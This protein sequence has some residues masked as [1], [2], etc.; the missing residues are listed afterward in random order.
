[1]T[2]EQQVQNLELEL[3]HIEVFFSFVPKNNWR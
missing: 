1:M 3:S 2:C